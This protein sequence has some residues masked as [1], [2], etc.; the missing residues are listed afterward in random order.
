MKGAAAMTMMRAAFSTSSSCAAST[1]AP[2]AA[3]LR[4][5]VLPYFRRHWLFAT[6]GPAAP[7]AAAE[8]AGLPRFAARLVDRGWAYAAGQWETAARAEEGTLRRRVYNLALSLMSNIKPSESFLMSVPLKAHR[9]CGSVVV[10]YPKTMDARVV[11][12]RLA[13]LVRVQAAEHRRAMWMWCAAL[14]VIMPIGILPVPNLPFYWNVYRIYCNWRAAQGGEE[15][16]KLIADARD[17]AGGDGRQP[18]HQPRAARAEAAFADVGVI[19]GGGAGGGA[20]G[21][22]AAASSAASADADGGDLGGGGARGLKLIASEWLDAMARPK[23]RMTSMLSDT[24]ARTIARR[25]NLASID[26][27]LVRLRNAAGP[28]A[29]EDV[30]R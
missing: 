24:K 11:H 10:I 27:T 6:S 18:P 15:L 4:L 23:R 29:P 2:S 1:S 8:E 19:G 5:V 16:R 3:A 22:P 7:G 14:P 25:F 21:A 20:D 17:A 9:E 26:E 12:D 30:D 13:S 28:D